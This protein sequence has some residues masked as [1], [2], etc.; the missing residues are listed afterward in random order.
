MYHVKVSLLCP[1]FVSTNIHNSSDSFTGKLIRDDIENY[2]K[3]KSNLRC[4][5]MEIQLEDIANHVF[6][7]IENDKFY[8]LTHKNNICH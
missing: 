7:A 8:I 1:A 4:Q 5:N 6:D 3:I 2:E